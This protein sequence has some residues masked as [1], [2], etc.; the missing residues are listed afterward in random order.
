MHVINPLIVVIPHTHSHLVQLIEN[1]QRNV[2]KEVEGDF[3]VPRDPHIVHDASEA[4]RREC[5]GE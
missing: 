3:V 4:P 1:E 5:E 2:E